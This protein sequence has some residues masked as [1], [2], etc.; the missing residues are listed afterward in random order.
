MTAGVGMWFNIVVPSDAGS[1][2]AR[3]DWFHFVV[4]PL[5]IARRP[6]LVRIGLDIPDMGSGVLKKIKKVRKIYK[7]KQL[8]EH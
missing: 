7:V 2:P 3:T 5:N 4:A 1:N 6:T 8:I